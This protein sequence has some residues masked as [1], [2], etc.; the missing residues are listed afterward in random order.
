MPALV[1]LTLALA[2]FSKSL[3]LSAKTY[4]F[5][6]SKVVG[7][8]S[9]AQAMTIEKN[10]LLWNTDRPMSHVKLDE[11]QCMPL[12]LEHASY[13]MRGMPLYMNL[14]PMSDAEHIANR[15]HK[16]SKHNTFAI[17]CVKP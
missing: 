5:E 7:Q 15:H 12:C 17:W 13:E 2:L 4:E 9:E 16:F 8:I 10:L 6:K 1:A 14:V 3:R 11:G